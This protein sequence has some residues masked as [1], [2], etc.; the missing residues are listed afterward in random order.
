MLKSYLPILVF[1]VL[2]LTVGGA[3]A[4]LNHLIGP[5]KPKTATAASRRQGEPYE[6]GIPVEAMKGFRFGVSF[7]LVAMLFILFDIEVVFLYPVG[8]ILKGADSVFVL[9]EMITFIVLL[10]IGFLYVWRKGALDWR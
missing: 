7:Y 9:G 1:A 8:V 4:M 3:F 5:K 10:M 6:S 2:G